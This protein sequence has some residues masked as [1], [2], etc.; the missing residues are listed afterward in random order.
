MS[1]DD[2]AK[3]V[4]ARDEYAESLARNT[5][6]SDINKLISD[7]CAKN[8]IIGPSP[9]LSDKACVEYLFSVVDLE[10]K[11]RAS[12]GKQMVDDYKKGLLRSIIDILRDN[13]DTETAEALESVK[14]DKDAVKR[15]L[16]SIYGAK[17][18]DDV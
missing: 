4:N 13:G 11:H 12:V 3:A 5:K 9:Y 17:R 1:A 14:G 16:N 10:R 18:G 8:D 2:F 7:Y 6:R 15:A